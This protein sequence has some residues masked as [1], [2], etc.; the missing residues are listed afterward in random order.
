MGI[1]FLTKYAATWEI[2]SGKLHLDGK[3]FLLQPRVTANR[4]RRLYSVE[5]VVRIPERS[6][7]DIPVRVTWPTMH[8]TESDWLVES[9]PIGENLMVGR[10]L[11]RGR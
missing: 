4:V 6:Q 1:D 10:T 7:T 11:S 2:A 3:C 5:P 9:K 8:P